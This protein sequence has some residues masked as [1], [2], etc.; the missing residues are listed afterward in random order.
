MNKLEIR[1]DDAL[2]VTPDT[3]W[4]KLAFSQFDFFKRFKEVDKVFIEHHVVHQVAVLAEGI[5]VYPEWVKYIKDRQPEMQVEMH[6]WGHVN[7]RIYSKEFGY[8]LLKTAKEKI[9]DVFQTKITRWYVPHSWRCFPDWSQEVCDRLGINFHT[10]G[11]QIQHNYFHYWN[12]PSVDKIY[13]IL[14][15]NQWQ[16]MS[17]L[18]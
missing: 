2:L 5:D 8:Q 14:E 12:Q 1:N 16:A 15:A 11:G 13:K 17:E 18:K 3:Q 10:H 6:G 4:M 7:Y 9:E